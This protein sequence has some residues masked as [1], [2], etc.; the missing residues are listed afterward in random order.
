MSGFQ[1]HR[2][3]LVARQAGKLSNNLAPAKAQPSS[4]AQ[5]TIHVFLL[6]KKT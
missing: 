1:L 4:L 6:L 3:L 5:V 2:G